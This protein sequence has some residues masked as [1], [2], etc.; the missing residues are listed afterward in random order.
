M[1]SGICIFPINPEIKT[2]FTNGI[3][4]I[5]NINNSIFLGYNN[6]IEFLNDILKSSNNPIFSYFIDLLKQIITEVNSKNA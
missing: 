1:Y 5:T 4:N 3:I 2:V 6:F